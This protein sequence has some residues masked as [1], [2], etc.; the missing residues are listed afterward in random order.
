[1]LTKVRK[2]DNFTKTFYYL[3]FFKFSCIS[4]QSGELRIHNLG[5][6]LRRTYNDFL[7]TNYIPGSVEARSTDVNRTKESLKLVLKALYPGASIPTTST[8]IL[9]DTLLFPQMC[10]RLVTFF[11]K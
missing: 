7:G 5:K 2:L 10:P 4:F 1:M 9:K 3:L 8:P 6:I 11:L